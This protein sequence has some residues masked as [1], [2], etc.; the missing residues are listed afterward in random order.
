MVR[1][2]DT[3]MMQTQHGKKFRYSE[4]ETVYYDIMK[5]SWHYT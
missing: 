3:D 5:N 2:V 4:Y 1:M